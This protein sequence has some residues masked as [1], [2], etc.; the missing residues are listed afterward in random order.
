MRHFRPL[1]L[2]VIVMTGACSGDKAST[3]TAS[4]PASNTAVSTPVDVT[5]ACALLSPA[6]FATV[7]VTVDAEGVDVSENFN[8]ATTS[9]VACQW[10]NFDNNVGGSWE[11]VIG[12]GDAEAAFAS[13]LTFAETNTVTRPQLGDDAYLEDKVS[14]FDSA[15]H[16][17]AAGVRIGDTYFT[18]ST[19]DDGG[20]DAITALAT[21]VADQLAA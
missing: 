19:T 9:S 2:A 21:L 17:F 4:T 12:K 18:L 7:G 10:T 20:A 14:S 8:L 6:D 16:D 5:D 11:L 15:D 13:D 3:T 1:V